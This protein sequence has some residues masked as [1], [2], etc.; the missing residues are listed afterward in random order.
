MAD[1]RENRSIEHPIDATSKSTLNKHIDTLNSRTDKKGVVL[2][3]TAPADQKQPKAVGDNDGRVPTQA[4]NDALVG[5]NTD[6][7]VGTGNK[8]VTQ[9]GLQDGAEVFGVDAG[10]DDTYVITLSPVPAAL[11]AGQVFHFDAN[12]ANTGAA[13]L[14]VNGLGAKTIKKLHDQDLATGDIEAGQHVTVIYDG[15]NFQMQ[16]QIAAD[17]PTVTPTNV[18][19][20]TSND[21][22]TKPSG[23]LMVEVYFIGAGGGGSSGARDTT[24]AS[25]GGGGGGGGF[26]F[27]RFVASGLSATEAIVVGSGGTGGAAQNSNNPGNAGNDGGDSSFG[28]NLSVADGGKGAA[29]APNSE[30]GGAAGLGGGAN[31]DFT[32]TGGTGG[33]GGGTA[34]GS[35]GVDTSTIPSPR[36]GGGGASIFTGGL[37]GGNGGSFITRYVKTGG[38]G[39]SGEGGNGTAGSATAS[40][41]LF[42]GVGGGGG[43]NSRTGAGNAGAGANGGDFSSGGGGGGAKDSSDS[44]N[45]GAGGNGASGLVIVIS[46]F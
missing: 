33:T 39:G 46:Y 43:S 37:S 8:Y 38:N 23:A 45:S 34:S 32:S 7:A 30:A 40:G 26:G 29:A 21:T 5:N 25:G 3:S 31:G 1:E 22:W 20:F 28:T 16:S 2:I 11:Q 19:T 36:G 17:V 35:N 14:N 27:K 13:T 12:T 10:S 4:E 18:Q 42:G 41:L 15:T 24:T 9:T 6:I 44:G